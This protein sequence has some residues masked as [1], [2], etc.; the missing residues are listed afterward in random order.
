VSFYFLDYLPTYIESMHNPAMF[1][2]GIVPNTLLYSMDKKGKGKWTL[3][4]FNTVYPG[5][6]IKGVYL[7]AGKTYYSTGIKGNY[8]FKIDKGSGAP[9]DDEQ[10]ATTAR[11][12]REK[13]AGIDQ[14]ATAAKDIVNP[15]SK[16][17]ETGTREKRKR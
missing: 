11:P 6:S 17:K 7:S 10:T 4:E 12:K 16:P 14:L 5:E 8:T 9:K 1:I 2:P 3:Q 13:N 15:V